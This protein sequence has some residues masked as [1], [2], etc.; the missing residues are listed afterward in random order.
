MAAVD[1]LLRVLRSMDTG[2]YELLLQRYGGTGFVRGNEYRYRLSKWYV[3]MIAQFPTY[4]AAHDEA[5]SVALDGADAGSTKI[6]CECGTSYTF[7][8]DKIV[9]MG[10]PEFYVFHQ[11]DFAWQTMILPKDRPQWWQFQ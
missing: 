10:M 11:I 5:V 1:D 9:G 4:A 2:A 7:T 6:T 3:D 8:N